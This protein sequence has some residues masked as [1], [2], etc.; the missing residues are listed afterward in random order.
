MRIWTLIAISV[1][2]LRVSVSSLGLPDGRPFEPSRRLVA[3]LD[4]FRQAGWT[5]SAAESARDLAALSP[6]RPHRV[7]ADR[8]V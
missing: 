1:D 6:Y 2:I 3:R 5:L 7:L 4:G 8:F